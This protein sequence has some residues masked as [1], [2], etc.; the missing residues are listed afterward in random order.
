M[1]IGDA[2][3][4]EFVVRFLLFGLGRRVLRRPPRPARPA[5]AAVGREEQTLHDKICSTYVIK[6]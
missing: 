4:R 6:A 3:L 2:L 1:T 5:L